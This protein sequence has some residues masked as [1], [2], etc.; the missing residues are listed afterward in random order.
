MIDDTK[1]REVFCRLKRGNDYKYAWVPTKIA[2]FGMNLIV[3]KKDGEIENGWYIIRVNRGKTRMVEIS[4]DDK[5]GEP[6]R[7]AA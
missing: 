4:Q 3:T 5:E 6:T 2:N 1:K 7:L